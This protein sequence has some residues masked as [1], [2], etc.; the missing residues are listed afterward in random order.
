MASM[1]Y[2]SA[3]HPFAVP[4][5]KFPPAEVCLQDAD[6]GFPARCS[7][8]CFMCFRSHFFCHLSTHL[9]WIFLLPCR[10]R[11][12]VLFASTAGRLFMSLL[13]SLV[14]PPPS[15]PFHSL[16]FFPFFILFMACFEPCLNWFKISWHRLDNASFWQAQPQ[17]TV[18]W[19]K[20][21]RKAELI[22]LLHT[23]NNLMLCQDA[24]N[25]AKSIYYIKLH[26]YY[27]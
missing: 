7:L 6:P 10:C 23:I 8:A 12:F 27:F 2:L 9:V 21:G 3:A 5:I 25:T 11:S 19:G 17:W 16:L 18:E 26:L 15:L 24:Y 20:G 1:Y 13:T 22:T 4:C 14:G